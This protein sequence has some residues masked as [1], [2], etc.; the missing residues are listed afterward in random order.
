L[1]ITPQWPVA[2]QLELIARLALSLGLGAVVGFER[3]RSRQ[4]AGFRTHILVAMGAALFTIVSAYG[5]EGEV[6]DPTRIAAQIVTGIGFIGAG[7]VLHHRGSIRGLTT[8]A[9]LWA[10]AAVG[11]A[12]GAGMYVMALAGTGLILGTLWILDRVADVARDAGVLPPDTD[13][14]IPDDRNDK[15]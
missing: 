10:V 9:S 7:A 15:G 14:M 5:F 13:R 4:A 11:M 1:D 3:E 2:V 6:V 12:A 8:A